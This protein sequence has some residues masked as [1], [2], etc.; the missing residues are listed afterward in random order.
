MACNVQQP[1]TIVVAESHLAEIAT[2][3]CVVLRK[4]MVEIGV[5]LA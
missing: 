2:A 3:L 1:A 4:D 5:M